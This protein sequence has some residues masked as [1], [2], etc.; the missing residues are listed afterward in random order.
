MNESDTFFCCSSFCIVL[1]FF[2][3]FQLHLGHHLFVHSGTTIIDIQFVSP[4][5]N[6][7]SSSNVHQSRELS[8]IVYHHI[9]CQYVR[10]DHRSYLV[11]SYV[12]ISHTSS[13]S[14]LILELYVYLS[15]HCHITS[16]ISCISVSST[17]PLSAV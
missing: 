7:K 8:E 9:I 16:H 1:Q 15:Y 11:I 4:C 6:I 17:P 12:M 3:N 13:S 10:Q 5:H 2:Q 14:I